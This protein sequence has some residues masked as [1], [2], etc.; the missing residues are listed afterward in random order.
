MKWNTSVSSH[1]NGEIEVR[2]EPLL[3]LMDKA[4]FTEAV[5][6]LLAKK[7]P[8]AQEAAMLNMVL[9][10]CIEHGIQ[11]PSSFVPRISASVG[12]SM[13]AALASGLL[14]TGTWHGG[15]VEGAAKFLQSE[16]SAK[17][18]IAQVLA[19][20]E[21]MPGFGHRQYKD[22]DP[23]AQAL[24]KKARE[25]GVAG[26]HI[27]RAEEFEKELESQSGKHLPINI[28]GAIAAVISDLG[29]DW[30]LGNAFFLLGRLPGMIA[31]IH[32]EVLNEKPYRRL[33]ESDVVEA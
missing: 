29:F 13:N 14:A 12:N 21:R 25:L 28:D 16:S 24:F 23:R 20:K 22:Q 10:S 27:T 11:S 18:I 9:V 6:L 26:Q 15:A 5:Y 8:S 32:E 17:E 7:M 19:Q 4:S 31:H 3:S 1:K 33:E 30:R 2:G